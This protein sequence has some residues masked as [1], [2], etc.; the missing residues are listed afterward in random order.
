MI[1][2]WDSS[3]ISTLDSDGAVDG[4][5]EIKVIHGVVV[6][7]FSHVKLNSTVGINVGLKTSS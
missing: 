1:R 7:Q 2:T 5:T 4:P 3:R 6:P